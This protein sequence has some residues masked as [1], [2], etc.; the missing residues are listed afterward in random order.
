MS[1]RATTASDIWNAGTPTTDDAK[2]F[3][4]VYGESRRTQTWEKLA[5]LRG[6]T[7]N[8][9]MSSRVCRYRK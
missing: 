3:H 2:P 7:G 6:K 8:A 1:A 9:V 5:I 4:E